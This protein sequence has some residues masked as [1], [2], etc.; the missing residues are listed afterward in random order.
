MKL[1]VDLQC[2]KCHMKVKKVLGKF[3]Q[4]LKQKYDAENNIVI[5]EVLCCNPERLVDKICCRSDGAIKSIEIV[6][7]KP[8]H[9][10]KPESPKVHHVAHTEPEKPKLHHPKPES[11]K[12]HHVA[13]IELEKPKSPPRQ[14]AP[15]PTQPAKLIEPVVPVPILAYPSTLS[16]SPAG[17]FYEGGPAGFQGFYGRPIYDSYGGSWP[18]YQNCHYHHFHEEEASQCRIS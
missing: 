15:A 14:E 10:P 17:I 1:K 12:V 7:A 4:I 9:H 2:Y 13:H 5:I 11:P 3:P 6:E 8:K 16:A 18:C